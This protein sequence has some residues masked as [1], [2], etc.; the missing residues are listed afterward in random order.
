[1][2]TEKPTHLTLTQAADVLGY[3][4]TRSVKELIKAKRLSSFRY[5]HRPKRLVVLRSEVEDLLQPELV[6][7]R[8]DEA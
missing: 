7:Q 8:E 5:S 1:M 6:T 4:S 3:T 2:E